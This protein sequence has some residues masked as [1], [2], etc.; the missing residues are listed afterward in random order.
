M[1]LKTI[2]SSLIQLVKACSPIFVIVEGKYDTGFV[3]S[4]IQ[5]TN[6]TSSKENRK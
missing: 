3:E 6:K 4:V 5:N 2:L 1:P